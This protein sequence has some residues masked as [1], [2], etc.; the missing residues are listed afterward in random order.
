LLLDALEDGT[1]PAPVVHEL[2]IALVERA[3]TAA[4]ARRRRRAGRT[5]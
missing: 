5:A 2:P 4:R 3:T 1:P